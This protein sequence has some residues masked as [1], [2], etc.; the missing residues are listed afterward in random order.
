MMTSLTLNANATA[1]ALAQG[2]ALGAAKIFR[3]R[4]RRAAQY[5][6]SARQLQALA[7][8]VADTGPTNGLFA[9]ERAMGVA[10]HH[11]AISGTAVQEVNDDYIMRLAAGRA[12]AFATVAEALAAVSGYTGEVFSPC[13]LSNVTLCAPLEA[14]L[15]TVVLVYNALG[16]ALDAAPVRLAAG[17]PPGVA[18]WAVLDTA[19]R[20][21]ARRR[22]ADGLPHRGRAER[23]AAAPAA[24]AGRRQPHRHAQRHA[25]PRLHVHN[26]LGQCRSAPSCARRPRR[27]PD[28]ALGEVSKPSPARQRGEGTRGAGARRRA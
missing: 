27:A 8:G 16:Q 24:A 7:G 12:E 23:D 26:G 10:Q 4:Q 3:A 28:C 17:L 20:H 6:Q 14:G 15:P 9:L 5:V 11:D 19:G 1:C 21:G 22:R 2:A 18:S 13:E 25:D